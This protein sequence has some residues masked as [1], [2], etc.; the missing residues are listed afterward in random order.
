MHLFNIQY[1]SLQSLIDTLNLTSN[2]DLQ[3]SSSSIHALP[4]VVYCFAQ[5]DLAETCHTT[6]LRSKFLTVGC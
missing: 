4:R 2:W 3:H 1:I 6:I 5:F